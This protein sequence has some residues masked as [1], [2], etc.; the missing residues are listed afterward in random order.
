[1]LYAADLFLIPE[2]KK[3]KCTK[4]FI[5]KVAK[6]QRQATLCITSTM[7]SSPIDTLDACT[8]LLPF[9]I[10]VEKIMYCTASRLETLPV[11]PPTE[12]CAQGVGEVHQK[13]LGAHSQATTFF[14]HPTSKV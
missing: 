9:H 11:P 8:D 3:R 4:D 2:R 6:I 5:T 14:L 13:P 10:L 1:M 7:R 12:A